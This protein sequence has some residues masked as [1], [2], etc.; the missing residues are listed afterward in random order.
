MKQNTVNTTYRKHFTP[1]IDPAAVISLILQGERKQ[2]LEIN[3]VFVD[4]REI[5]AINLEYRLKNRETDVISFESKSGGDIFISV[6][7][8]R[9]QAKE[10]G[11]GLSEEII[12]LTVHGTLHVLGYDH[13]KK[14]DEKKMKPKE[15]K[16]MKKAMAGL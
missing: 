1:G 16:Y 9:Q 3:L 8:A 7:K 13:I 10:Y 14:A 11:A 15:N 6:D 4:N 12:R 2:G 5:K